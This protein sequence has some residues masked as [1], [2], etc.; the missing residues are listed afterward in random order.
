[1]MI[2]GQ[3]LCESGMLGIIRVEFVSVV[4]GA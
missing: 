1:L 2:D 3:H 4:R